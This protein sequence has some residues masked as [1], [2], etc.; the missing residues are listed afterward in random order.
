MA[1]PV[2][3]I[4]AR[5]LW[6]A[7]TLEKSH[8]KSK[9]MIIKN[10]YIWS[11]NHARRMLTRHAPP[12][13][14]ACVTW[15][16]LNIHEHKWTARGCRPNSSCKASARYLPVARISGTSG[17]PLMERLDQGIFHPKLD[18]LR[19]PWFGRELNP[20]F[21]VDGE[22][23][24]KEPLIQHVNGFS[25]HQHMSARTQRMLDTGWLFSKTGRK[26]SH[27]KNDIYSSN[28]ITTWFACFFSVFKVSSAYVLFFIYV[29]LATLLYLLPLRCG[30]VCLLTG[31]I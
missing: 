17:S 2:I 16:I 23:S 8:S 24:R 10:I 22:H 5:P 1:R 27:W 12:P 21:V 7:R 28:N 19:L 29:S 3:E 4:E 20:A 15:T 9:L 26:K 13:P 30:R 6:K 14:R 31:T 11:R 25:E 18:V